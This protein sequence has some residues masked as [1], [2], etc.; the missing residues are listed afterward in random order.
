MCVFILD[1]SSES[2]RG[3]LTRWLLEVKPGVLVGNLSKTVRERLWNKIKE[4]KLRGSLLIYS[5]KL[6]GQGY[7]IEM[8]GEPTRRVVDLDGVQLIERAIN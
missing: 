2:L 1:L 3:E 4:C 7:I 6:V 5:N 8:F